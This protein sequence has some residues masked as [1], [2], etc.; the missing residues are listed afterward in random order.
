MGKN[1]RL[2]EAKA[3]AIKV[4]FLEAVDILYTIMALIT[5]GTSRKF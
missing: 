1:R 4:R 5:S 3:D 2:S